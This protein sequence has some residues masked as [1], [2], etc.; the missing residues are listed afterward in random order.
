[1][2]ERL[3]IDVKRND[4]R[5]ATI[6]FHWSAYTHTAIRILK[7]MNRYVFSGADKM[8][9]NDVILSVI[10]FAEKNCGLG[11][12]DSEDTERRLMTKF[13]EAMKDVP[14]SSQEMFEELFL[15][16]GGI[17]PLCIEQAV[18]LFPNEVFLQ[19][20]VNRNDGLVAITEEIMESQLNNA[21]GIIEVDIGKNTV[22][23]GMVYT[24]SISEY[25]DET[26]DEDDFYFIPPDKI[27]RSPVALDKFEINEIE[28][29]YDVLWTT[30]SRWVR[31]NDKIYETILG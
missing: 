29:A 9:D 13:T 20:A 23:N 12:I 31:F 6:H 27:L 1:M 2:G 28:L 4:K 16:N 7:S 5:L 11:F 10:R 19:D 21:Q 24:Y 15:G 30:Q 22:V 18:S 17:H 25:L 8:S 26:E 3:V 14:P